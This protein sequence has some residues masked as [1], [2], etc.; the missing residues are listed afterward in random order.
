MKHL[1]QDTADKQPKRIGV[2][3]LAF[4]AK[5]GRSQG[6]WLLLK[7]EELRRQGEVRSTSYFCLE[8]AF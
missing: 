4:M 1:A 2:A 3:T 5:S 8:L 6:V 7:P